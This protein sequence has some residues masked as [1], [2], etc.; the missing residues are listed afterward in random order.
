[1]YPLITGLFLGYG[2]M[3]IIG[4]GHA[5]KQLVGPRFPLMPP[6]AESEAD[7]DAKL[8]TP[9]TSGVT[10]PQRKNNM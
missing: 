10:R 5:A 3:L 7:R 9:L 8:L 1:M 2:L 6:D 4:L